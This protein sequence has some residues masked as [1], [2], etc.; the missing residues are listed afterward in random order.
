[1]TSPQAPSAPPPAPATMAPA[2]V[3]AWLGLIL[4][5]G[6][7]LRIV[8]GVFASGI[9]HPD[10][11][12]QSLEPAH[13]AVYGVGL[14]SWELVQGARPWT[15]P[16]LYAVLLRVLAALGIDE[17]ASY[18]LVIRLWNALIASTW[19][20]FC[21]RVARALRGPRA[22]LLAAWLTATWYFLV[23][24]AP[25]ALNHTFSLTFA[26]WALA[27]LVEGVTGP[28]RRTRSFVT[29]CLLGLAFAFRYQD[30]LVL[31]GALGFLAGERRWRELPGLLGGAALPALGVG[32]LD[33]LTW[34]LPFHSL[35][36]YLRSN[37]VHGAA[38]SFGVMPWWFYAVFLLIA[39]GGGALWLLLLPLAGRRALW[40]L[41]SVGGLVLVAHSLTDNKQ[42]RFVLPALALLFCALGCAGD[43]LLDRLRA[44]GRTVVVAATLLLAGLWLG[45]SLA[46]ARGLTFADLGMFEGQPEAD[47]SPWSFRRDLDRAL[48]EIGRR[49]D[50]CG[51]VVFPYGGAAGEARLVSTGGYTY[52]HRAA[53]LS[54]GP[55]SPAAAPA[56]NYALACADAQGRVMGPPGFEVTG[57]VGRCLILRRPD[58][59]CDAAA[60]ARLLSKARW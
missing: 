36:A 6:A 33:R 60:Q 22:G 48:T 39:L 56:T 12:H 20:W 29:G 55:L 32:L 13:G 30:G 40:L 46:R 45:S 59:R 19:P 8:Y 35:F 4:I 37:L 14:R 34:G 21:F 50:L 53:P 11:I 24:L 5:L 58:F 52:L 49:E 18:T 47:E 9:F 42:I 7:M 28:P 54:M 27:R 41:G 15:G 3:A 38:A 43:G 26:L 17:P 44:R 23:L 2:R 31:V 51:L 25:R 16:G 10:E 1:M 57:R